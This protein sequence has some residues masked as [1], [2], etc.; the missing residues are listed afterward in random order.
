ME[1]KDLVMTDLN[2]MDLNGANILKLSFE[3]QTANISFEIGDVKIDF[4]AE[5][6]S[7][8]HVTSL[9]HGDELYSDEEALDKSRAWVE[10]VWTTIYPT[11]KKHQTSLKTVDPDPNVGLIT[12]E[13][14][15]QS[16]TNNI[17]KPYFEDAPKI[18]HPNADDANKPTVEEIKDSVIISLGEETLNKRLEAAEARGH[19]EGYK[20]A[21]KKNAQD[22]RKL[23]KK[24]NIIL[25]LTIVIL[26]GGFVAFL[27]SFGFDFSIL[28]QF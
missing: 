23:K 12:D 10:Y 26:L 11:I 3:D 19:K 7:T 22:M 21:R 4:A 24:H 5:D 13:L 20:A 28:I 17:A 1:L 8:I 18:D 16:E 9:M 15:D 6:E 14:E 25:F 2:S 27:H